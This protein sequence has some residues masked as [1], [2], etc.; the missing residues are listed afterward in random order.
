M[1]LHELQR[2]FA[3]AVLRENISSAIA[4]DVVGRGLEPARRL[5][6][7]R[8]NIRFTLREALQDIYPAT[9]ALVG[10]DFF[11]HLAKRYLE[12]HPPESGNILD[13]G[14]CLPEFISSFPQLSSLPYLA[15]VS[16]V[17]WF[18]H[19]AFHSDSADPC[20]ISQLGS[21][22]PEQH[23]DLRLQLHPSVRLLQSRYPVFD[24]WR[25]AKQPDSEHPAPDPE[26]APQC[27]MV[28]RQHDETNV[29][30]ME[31]TLYEF[32]RLLVNGTVLGDAVTQ[33]L[34]NDPHYDLQL[35][36]HRLF[37]LRTIAGISIGS[38]SI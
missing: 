18:T 13:V 8:N 37:S 34:E 4:S 38:S 19:E 26:S 20:D 36:L 30:R 33:L 21:F 9:Y 32:A 27:V 24:I 11:K 10:G 14:A 1:Q 31:K 35:G 7:Y 6:V 23:A 12:T 3:S 25:F 2:Q 22:A 17:D 15:D 5:Q 29:F 28:L 16:K